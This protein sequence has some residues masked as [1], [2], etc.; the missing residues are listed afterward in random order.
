MAMAPLARRRVLRDGPERAFAWAESLPEDPPEDALRFKLQLFRRVASAAASVDV[1]ATAAWAARHAQG[2]NGDGLLARVGSVWAEQPGQGER[3]LRWLAEQPPGRQR[4]DG[5]RDTY[6]AWA[7]RDP[8]AAAAWLEAE[9][10]A[11]WLEAAISQHAIRITREQP[12][13]ALDW[14]RRIR[15]E[16]LRTQAFVAVGNVWLQREP[17]AARA[18]LDGAEPTPEIRQQILDLARA[19]DARRAERRA[20][21]A[22]AEAAA[23]AAPSPLP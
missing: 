10:H 11:E 4:D 13:E 16:P 3:A 8:A 23:E 22:A 17:D 2:P 14:A 5:V 7:A 6:Q 21:R 19:R 12:D 9:P 1:E 18:W 15:T 20:A